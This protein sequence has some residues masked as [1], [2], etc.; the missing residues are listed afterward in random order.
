MTSDVD[1]DP[2]ATPGGHEDLH[3][4]NAGMMHILPMPYVA[5]A[6]WAYRERVCRRTCRNN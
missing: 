2:M 6:T 3:L 1:G 4:G 5:I